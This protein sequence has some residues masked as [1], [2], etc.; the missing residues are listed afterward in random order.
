VRTPRVHTVAISVL[1]LLVLGAGLVVVI[2]GPG[3]AVGS[4]AGLTAAERLKA[5]NDVRATLLQGL[6]GLLALG[7]V[8]I[9]AAM[10]VRQVRANRE[11][12]TIGLF[13]KAIDQLASE[14]LSV[15][16]GG[17]YALEHLCELDDRYHGHVHA[18]LTA[19]VRQHA[20]W[21]PVK[22][23]A[24][25]DEERARFHGGLADD[26][27]AAIGA[28]G[29][30]SMITEGAGSE[31]ERAD[32]RGAELRKLDIPRL[33]LAHS[34][35]DGAILAGAKLA[36]A[37]LEDTSLRGADLSGADLTAANLTDADLRGAN[38]S[39]ATL[40]GADLTGV[41]ADGTTT[42]PAGFAPDRITP[43]RAGSTSAP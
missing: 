17:V 22:P 21:P 42:W 39:G 40:E 18:L 43:P 31:L 28:L 6:G 12:N 24:E 26:V 3:W 16:H 37:T 25:L 36:G 4:G 7:G 9:G 11:G 13:T 23:A 41:I 32:L 33:C 38:L 14:Q 30:Q 1:V 29:R 20:P 10:T 27:G 35:V 34:N 8:A 2:L 19:F 15:R 5:E